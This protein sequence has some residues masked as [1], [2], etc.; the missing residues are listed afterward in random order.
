MQEEG[1]QMKTKI[2]IV[3]TV[4]ILMAIGFICMKKCARQQECFIRCVGISC[5]LTFWRCKDTSR[6]KKQEA[7]EANMKNKRSLRFCNPAGG[8]YDP[9]QNV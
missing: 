4:T 9:A 6:R 7:E 3:A 2:S 8:A 5:D 1:M